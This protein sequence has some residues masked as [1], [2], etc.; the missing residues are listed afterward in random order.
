MGRKFENGDIVVFV[1]SQNFGEIGG[2]KY[3]LL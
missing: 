3:K 1:P 2:L